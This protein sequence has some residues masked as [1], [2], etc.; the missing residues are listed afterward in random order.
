MSL[1]IQSILIGLVAYFGYMHNFTGSTMVNRP[2]V[3]STLTGLVLGDMETGIIVGAAL[4]LAF[5][6]A[7]PIGAS[8]PPDMTSGS[9][10]GTAFVIL[11]GAS[12]G[13]AV[14]L[15]IPVA[16]LVLL[17][18]NL[19]MMFVLTWAAHIADK[20]AEQG[21]A[22]KVEWICRIASAFLAQGLPAILVAV[23]FYAGIDAIQGVLAYIPDWVSHGMDVAAGIL[24]AIGFAMLARM[25]LSKELIAFLLLG[26]LLTAYLNVPVLG[27]ALF[28]L[29]VALV[30]YFMSGN[31]QG[32]TATE[33]Y[34]D[35]NE[36]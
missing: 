28:G 27:V 2:I 8:N 13:T 18:N 30:V 7:V 31:K 5:L 24:P 1:G 9:I 21:D 15:A 6:G 29:A 14:T 16:T 22:T 10:I 4:E 33:V 11:S 23:A 19:L 17:F 25:I 34:E 35:D 12:T 32:S 36:F 3:M 26:F 20:Y